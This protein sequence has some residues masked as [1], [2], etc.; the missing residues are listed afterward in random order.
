[1][2]FKMADKHPYISGGGTLVKIIEHLR[3]SF[4]PAV[5]AETLKKLGLAPNNES[6]V[7]GILR[8]I[9]VLDD[10]GKKTSDASTVFSKHD[11]TEFQDGFSYL[12]KTAYSDL[13]ALHGDAAWNLDQDKLISYFRSADHSSELVGRRQ[14]TTFQALAGVAGKTEL[15]I[16]RNTPE[17][18][19]H[20]PRRR[21]K[22]RPVTKTGVSLATPGDTGDKPLKA[23]GRNVG[24]TVRVEVNLPATGDQETYDR[25]FRS[26]RENLLNAE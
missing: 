7:I 9:K 1:M 4:P 15:P 16:T 21:A 8:F 13:F 24:L 11:N 25:I 10:E 3:R 17:Q 5:T 20:K 19:G 6:F 12:V 18:N 26:I 23:T 14:A 2:E 22:E